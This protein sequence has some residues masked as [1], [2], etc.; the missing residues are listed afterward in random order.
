MFGADVYNV[1]INKNRSNPVMSRI[2]TQGVPTT[3]LQNLDELFL[4]LAE[5]KVV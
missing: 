3:E 2:K 4:L 5:L 1:K